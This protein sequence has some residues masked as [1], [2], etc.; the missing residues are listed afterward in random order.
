MQIF[1]WTVR[2]G[3]LSS[4]G[5]VVTGVNENSVRLSLGHSCA[6]VLKLS[7]INKNDKSTEESK[8]IK[9]ELNYEEI[10]SEEPNLKA[11]GHGEQSKEKCTNFLAD[12]SAMV[13]LHQAFYKSAFVC[14]RVPESSPYPTSKANQ[15][16]TTDGALMLTKLRDSLI[17][18]SQDLVVVEGITP[19]K[20]FALTMRHRIFS[21]KV[22]S[23]LEK[24]VNSFIF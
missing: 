7:K 13:C 16:R 17:S 12:M 5:L 24:L 11:Q 18:A 6:L 23:E 1:E 10:K 14:P 22:L 21:F 4:S 15:S 8:M 20:Y 2:E 9:N 19:L 3:L